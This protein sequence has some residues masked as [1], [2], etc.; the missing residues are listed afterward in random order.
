MTLLLIASAFVLTALPGAESYAAAHEA[1]ARGQYADAYKQYMTCAETDA[2][3]RP[4]ALVR[5]A[6]SQARAGDAV[7]AI[8]RLGALA[9]DESTGPAQRLAQVELA[10]WYERAKRPADAAALLRHAVDV[11]V[12]PRFLRAYQLTLAD[13]L[14]ASETGRSEGYALCARLLTEARTR[15]HRLEAA[16]RLAK[17]PDLRQALDAAD[18]FLYSGEDREA[19]RV[20]LGLAPALLLRG[21]DHRPQSLYLQGRLQLAAK[22]GTGRI[23]L[24]EVAEN[25]PDS[26]WAADALLYLGRDLHSAGQT[27]AAQAAFD[28][29]AK[30]YPGTDATARGLWWLGQRLSSQGKREEGAAVLLKLAETC[31]E[32]KLADDAILEAG[33][34][35][36]AAKKTKEAI[37]AYQRLATHHPYAPM[38]GEALFE[39][40]RLKES[41]GDTEGAVGDYAKAAR[42]IGQFYAHR[43]AERLQEL[44]KLAAPDLKATGTVS[45]IRPIP[46]GDLPETDYP[47]AVKQAPWF[48]RL[49]F[50]ASLG[51]E[52]AEWEGIALIPAIVTSPSPGEYYRVLSDAGLTA[53]A[54]EI[55]EETGWGLK[56][57]APTFER[58]RV[59]YP[60]A[61]WT[62]VQRVARETGLDPYL[63][64]AVGRQESIFQ[65]RVVSV[66][67]ATGVMQLMPGTAEWLAKIE[68]AVSKRQAE[69]LTQPANSLRL[70]AYYLIRMVDRNDANLVYALASYNAGP[71]NVSKWKKQIP[72]SDMEAFVEAIP[73]EETR[74][75]VKKVLGNYG[76]YHSLYPE[77]N[78]IASAR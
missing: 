1:E 71:G 37:A 75:F 21:A 56:D 9:M 58:L 78:R 69:N 23:I 42:L 16:E 8:E 30:D 59:F 38:T 34:L 44:G 2:V 19:K 22:D 41:L 14:I 28:S 68:P 73:F 36:R 65:S 39:S 26:P 3:L 60:R 40:G 62:E 27:D 55:A 67:G 53:M 72:T 77:P 6:R 46:L 48:Q 35:L 43:A 70:G 51:L 31:P 52:E 50:F 32:H 57:G 76:A 24:R 12:R 29:L 10:I 25:Y 64:L 61:Y 11:P 15:S 63:I 20:L 47:D 18:A 66:A 7:A 54:A 13:C 74:G 49:T 17:S 45:F 5:G 4:Y 33:N